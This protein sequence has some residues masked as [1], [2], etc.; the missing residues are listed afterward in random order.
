M[1][2]ILVS[3]KGFKAIVK[4]RSKIEDLRHYKRFVNQ[5]KMPVVFYYVSENLLKNRAVQGFVVE[6]HQEPAVKEVQAPTHTFCRMIVGGR[7]KRR[8]KLLARRTKRR[9]YQLQSGRERDKWRHI[10]ALNANEATSIFVPNSKRLTPDTFKEMIRKHGE[11]IIKPCR[12]SLGRRVIMIEKRGKR[13]KLSSK[14]KKKLVVKLVSAREVKGYIEA[15]SKKRYI[16]QQKVRA[17]KVNDQTIEVRASTQKTTPTD[18]KVSA[19]ALRLSRKGD[20]LTNISKGAKGV[21]FKTHYFK[22][23]NVNDVVEKTSVALAKQLSKAIPAIDFGFDLMV[24]ERGKVWFIE[25][26]LRD[27]KLTYMW[28]GEYELW[29]QSIAQPLRF[30]ASE[31]KKAK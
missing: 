14:T 2:G 20:F 24:D 4:G 22:Q 11:V 29:Y 30:I 25:A 28:A 27:M 23:A 21:P 19:K 12:G 26:N 10:V 8:L 1:I 7:T 9:F 17:T 3:K 16:V 5:H 15:L 6:P 13:Y 31:M 18:W